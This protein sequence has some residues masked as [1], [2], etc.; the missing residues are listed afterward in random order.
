[1]QILIE[2][3][4]YCLNMGDVAMLQVAVH[5]LRGI[6]PRARILAITSDPET[7]Q[8]YCPDVEPVF[9]SMRELWFNSPPIFERTSGCGRIEEL[10]RRRWPLLYGY[11]RCRRL[12]ADAL[13]RGLL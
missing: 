12:N 4:P 3:T 7:L 13:A 8:F 9:Q 10:V 11:I 1:M 5:R 2:G 6:W